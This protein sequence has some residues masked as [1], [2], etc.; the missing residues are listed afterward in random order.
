MYCCI[1]S[2]IT[3]VRGSSVPLLDCRRRI[4]SITGV[5]EHA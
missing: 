4:F 2:R 5:G 3:S 1:S